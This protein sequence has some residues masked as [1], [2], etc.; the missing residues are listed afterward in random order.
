MDDVS[1]LNAFLRRMVEQNRKYVDKLMLVGADGVFSS[2]ACGAAAAGD[3]SRRPESRPAADRASAEAQ[4]EGPRSPKA[5][6]A[7]LGACHAPESSEVLEH[8]VG[9]GQPPSNGATEVVVS[10]LDR[11]LNENVFDSQ[12]S[13]LAKLMMSTP[14]IDDA[15]AGTLLGG[16]GDGGPAAEEKR[17][18]EEVLVDIRNHAQ[19]DEIFFAFGGVSG[20]CVEDDPADATSGVYRVV[21]REEVEQ[22]VLVT[23]AHTVDEHR[24]LFL[25]SSREKIMACFCE[26]AA[27]KAARQLVSGLCDYLVDCE[28]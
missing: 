3:A 4:A 5:D 21:K 16:G 22:R 15:G 24:M 27:E 26:R 13:A 12:T 19:L 10:A 9:G 2:S 1:D 17:D 18:E 20:V 11:G 6:Q 14:G 28:L 23:L 7:G 25:D 8:T